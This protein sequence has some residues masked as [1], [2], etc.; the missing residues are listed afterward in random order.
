M[1]GLNPKM[2]VTGATGFIG[3]RLVDV[4]RNELHAEVTALAHRTSA[5]ALYLASRGVNLNFTPINDVAGLTSALAGHDAVIHL[6]YGRDGGAAERR[7]ITIEG[8]RALVDAAIASGVTQFVNVSTAAVYFGASGPVIDESAPRRKWGWDYADEKLTAEEI[9]RSATDG[10]GLRGSIFQ[11]AGVYGPGGETFVIN[12][13]TNMRR[14]FVVLPN[15]GQGIAN[16]TYVDD[17]VQA[18]ILGLKKEAVGETFIIKGPET[19]TR[20]EAHEKLEAML[21]YPTIRCM[22]TESVRS[23]L[24][25]EVE[26]RSLFQILPAALTALRGSEYFKSVVRTSPLMPLIRHARPLLSRRSES[27]PQ[28]SHIQ[29]ARKST[30]NQFPLIYPPEI[31]LDYLSAE[32]ELSSNKAKTLLGYSPRISLEEGMGRTEEWANWAG[33]I[34]PRFPQ[35]P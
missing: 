24:K 18:L 5:G 23:A 19:T 17:V 13:L 29:R 27:E 35:V 10:K 33:L 1:T 2:F 20:L 26:W 14:G 16:M 25:H 34:G 21:G 4:L 3:R 15:Q 32:V 30:P 11:V 7:S 9:V 22:S 31:L 8:T 12:P 28:D 6:A